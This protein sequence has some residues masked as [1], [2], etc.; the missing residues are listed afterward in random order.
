LLSLDLLHSALLYR[1]IQIGL[2]GAV[3]A[4]LMDPAFVLRIEDVTA[5]FRAA[6][7]ALQAGDAEGAAAALWPGAKET[8]MRVPPEL[9]EVLRMHETPKEAAAAGDSSATGNRSDCHGS[10]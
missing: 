1:S 4:V 6:A 7:A 10:Q 2:R 8:P 5:R 3:A 9:A